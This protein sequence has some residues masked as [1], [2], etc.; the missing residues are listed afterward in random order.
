MTEDLELQAAYLFAGR[1]GEVLLE[2][3]LG[4]E[5]DAMLKRQGLTLDDL[6]PRWWTKEP[7]CD[8]QSE[9]QREFPSLRHRVAHPRIGCPRMVSGYASRPG[10]F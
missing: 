5:I 10:V 2:S 4:D 6:M 1:S 3:G 7:R 9:H 8:L